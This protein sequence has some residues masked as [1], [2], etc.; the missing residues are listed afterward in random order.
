MAPEDII[1]MAKEVL[2]AEADAVR[3]QAHKVSTHFVHAVNILKEAQGKVVLTGMGKSGII[4]KKMASTFASTGTPAFFLHP[5][6]AIHG[7][8]GIISRDDVVIA[9]SN[10]GETKEI[11]A[12]LPVMKRMGVKI[13]AMVGKGGS[14]MA[15]YADVIIDVGVKGEACPLGIAPT[16]STTAALAVGDA[17]AVVLLKE[18]GFSLNDFALLH[19]GGTLGRRL[20]TVGDLMHRGDEVPLTR[21]EELLK[22]V[23][24]EISSKRLGITGVIDGEGRVV[25][26]ITDGDLRRAMERG[27][28]VYSAKAS[29]L[30]SKN[31]KKIREKDLA[32]SALAL[33]EK[34]KITS[35][36]VFD[37]NYETLAGIIH[38]HDLLRGKIT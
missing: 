30:M 14:T 26:V 16:S 5:A 18:K 21:S 20:K 17:L 27:V 29:E 34:N 3:D 1:A 22:N 2:L 6:E 31:P 11:I 13:I 23:L 33:M 25:G 32:A 15:G 9:L 24:F 38:I 8:V 35:L 19:P 37:D 12:L 4:C 36:F 28:D 10:S 7:D